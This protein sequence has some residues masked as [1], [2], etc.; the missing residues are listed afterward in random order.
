MALYALS[1]DDTD[2]LADYANSHQVTFPLLSDPDSEIIERFGILNTI[3]DPDD[4]PWYGIPYPGVY[5]TDS[6][7]RIVKKFFESS[8]QFR[9]S[10]EQLLRAALGEELQLPPMAPATESVAFDVDFD[11]NV[12]HAS[13]FHD[14]V[15]RFAV[16]EG[17]HLY[18]E[19]VPQGLVATSVE[20]EPDL[21]LVTKPAV[22]PPSTP[23]TL[24]G[25]GETLNV[26]EGDVTVRV[27]IAHLSR[28]LNQRDD[29]SF[30]QQV[31]GTIRWQSC[32]DHQCHLPRT[33]TFSIDIAAA[34][35]D[36]PEDELSKPGGMDVAAH[37]KR[38][39]A[40]RTAK[41]VGQVLTEMAGDIYPDHE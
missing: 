34:P 6:D 41:S 8:L 27:P 39:V 26:F 19:P 3:I 32:D 21:G 35:H 30:I 28:S 24:T 4:H 40:R 13:V 38:M 14:L 2:A 1:Y 25:S 5:V 20:I 16:P 17:Q 22:L 31:R 9:P 12:L 37:L 11:G 29:G 15:V 33:E 23:L 18:G 7:G 10:A 36:R